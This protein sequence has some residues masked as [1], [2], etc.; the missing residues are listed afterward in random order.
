MAPNS[1]SRGAERLLSDL[2]TRF[3]GL[4]VERMAPEIKCG[5]RELDEFTGT[6]RSTLFQFSPD[7]TCLSPVASWAR[8]GLDAFVPQPME[9]AWPSAHAQL[10]R[11][12]TLRFEHLPDNLPDEAVAGKAYI[13]HVSRQSNLTIPMP[14]ARVRSLGATQYGLSFHSHSGQ[15]EPMPF[16]GALVPLAYALVTTQGPCLTRPDLSGGIRRSGY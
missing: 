10:V 13:R 4:P 3:M 11:G 16:V 14:F 12:G 9:A 2:S 5:P 7:G 1:E 8:P 6:D 15:R